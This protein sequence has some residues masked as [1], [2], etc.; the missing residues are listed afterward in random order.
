MIRLVGDGNAVSIGYVNCDF[1]VEY[2]NVVG[3]VI[4]KYS[5]CPAG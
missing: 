5:I 1:V 2:N 3:T 4:S